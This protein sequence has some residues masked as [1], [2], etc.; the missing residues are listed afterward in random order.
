MAKASEISAEVT[1][2]A[3]RFVNLYETQ[4][5]A[6]WCNIMDPRLGGDA[7]QELIKEMKA[8]GWQSGWPY[9]ASLCEAVLR[10][11]YTNLKAPKEILD[12]IAKNLNPSSIQS[13][14]NTEKYR[15]KNP[16]PGS[17]FFMQKGKSSQGHA[18]IVCAYDKSTN[19]IA[20]IE[21][22]TSPGKA[23]SAEADRNGDGIYKKQRELKFT[24]TSGLFLI[25][26]FNPIEW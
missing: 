7:C 17:V 13:F 8:S 20:T 16:I 24:P 5:N 4:S 14:K 6:Q 1:K 26:F 9:C 3:T 15:S 23:V 21:G 10:I 25:G 22:N 2:V 11:S 19:L 18:G 12:Y